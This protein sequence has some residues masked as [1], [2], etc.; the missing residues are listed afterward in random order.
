MSVEIGNVYSRLT[1]VGK[2]EDRISPTSG[3][4]RKY[5]ICQ[6]SCE[7]A[8]IVEVREDGLTGS[9]TRSCG[10][11][12]DEAAAISRKTMKPRKPKPLKPLPSKTYGILEV[13]K[14]GESTLTPK[15]RKLHRWTCKCACGNVKDILHEEL[16]KG[17]VVSCGCLSRKYFNLG[18]MSANEE[19]ILKARDVHGDL[20]NYENS[21]YTHSQEYLKI[22]CE[23][24]GDFEQWPSNH[25]QGTGCPTC[26]VESRRHTPESFLQ[27]VKEIHED[28]YDY[29]L[30]DF[31]SRKEFVEIICKVHGTFSIR[32]SDHLNGRGCQECGQERRFIGLESFIER[33]NEIHNFKFDYSEVVY[34]HSNTKVKIICHDHGP[35]MQQPSGHLLGQQ[36]PKCSGERRALKQHWNHIKRCELDP[37]MAEGPGVLYLLEMNVNDENFLKVGISTEYKKRLGRYTEYGIDFKVLKLIETTALKSATL[38]SQVLKFVRNQDIRYVPDHD[39]KG[40]TECATIESKELLINYYEELNV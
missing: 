28:T 34:E 35:F 13:I 12:R 24:H 4:A 2:A 37:E 9:R 23:I 36:C 30:V 17:S 8:K 33:S 25:L 14:Q 1:V 22:T 21:V 19:F 29:S 16:V 31:K 15:G 18:C 27:K 10:C 6:C 38:E 3:K 7:K 11:L 20:Y 40:W 39:F 5:W 26:A 32:P